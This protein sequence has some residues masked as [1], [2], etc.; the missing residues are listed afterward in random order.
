M[1]TPRFPRILKTPSAG[2]GDVVPARFA[3]VIACILGAAIA[4]VALAP[5]PAEELES[6]AAE[7]ERAEAIGLL[8]EAGI[9]ERPTWRVGDAWRVQFDQGEP[10]CWLVVVDASEG[11]RQGVA[12]ET[13]EAEAIA[14][15]LAVWQ[16][17]WIASYTS[18]LEGVGDGSGE[19]TRWFDWPLEDGKSWSTSY[20]DVDLT[21]TAEL[22]EGAFE[23]TMVREEGDDVFA[24]YDFDPTLKWWSRIEFVESEY[25]FQVHEHERGW[26]GPVATAVTESKAESQSSVVAQFTAEFSTTEED[27]F[28]VLVYSRDGFGRDYW[29]LDGPGTSYTSISQGN[30]ISM[31]GATFHYGLVPA[32]AGDWTFR[33]VGVGLGFLVRLYSADVTIVE[34]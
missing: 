34:L 20:E 3:A 27:D 23:I 13:D 17:R 25:V 22:V 21:A 33:Q 14:V 1:A 12:C 4:V 30:V 15:N 10:V 8:R 29:Q 24:R 2:F 31:G 28:V 19:P 16:E 18:D 6:A 26:S 7:D 9:V 11:Y 5:A 32:D